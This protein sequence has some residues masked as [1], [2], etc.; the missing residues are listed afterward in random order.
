MYV[1]QQVS[2]INDITQHPEASRLLSIVTKPAP[3]PEAPYNGELCPRGSDFATASRSF[4]HAF[5]DLT[6]LSWEERFDDKTMQK[7]RAQLLN[8][9]P[10][11]YGKPKMGMPMGK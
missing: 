5:R 10:F 4:R 6:L 9:E 8:I 3:T 1:K 11:W 2:V 7:A